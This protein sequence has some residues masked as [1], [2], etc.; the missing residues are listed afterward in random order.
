M[1]SLGRIRSAYQA[2]PAGLKCPSDK[3]RRP[4]CISHFGPV[5]T[6]VAVSM[7]AMPGTSEARRVNMS[8]PARSKEDFAA[9][10]GVGNISFGAGT[11]TKIIGIVALEA[12]PIRRRTWA[13]LTET[14]L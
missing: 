3:R 8:R 12:S 1:R 14:H 11:Q 13:S 7:N 6:I 4:F 9:P 2:L 5:G 10:L